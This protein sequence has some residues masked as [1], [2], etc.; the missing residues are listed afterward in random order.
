M[1]VTRCRIHKGCHEIGG[2]CVEIESTSGERILID[3]GLPLEGE[4]SM[5]D[6][7]GLFRDSTDLLGVFI[8]H[9]HPDHYGLLDQVAKTTKVFIGDAA[10]KIIAASDFFTP[11]P[12]LGDVETNPLVANETIELGPFKLTPIPIDHSAFGSFCFLIEV[13]GKRIFYSGDIRAHG[14]QGH[15][16]EDLVSNPPSNI[17]VLIC[18]GTQIGRD[19]DF[20]FPDEKSVED[21]IVTQ[22]DETKG[23]GL[24]WCSSQN[25]DRVISA[26]EAAKRTDRHLIL[27]VYSAE[28]L[29]ASGS[30]D[31]PSPNADEVHIFLPRSQKS[32]IIREKRFEITNPY[33]PNRI[34]PEKLKEVAAKSVMIFRPSMLRELEAAN[35]LSNATCITSLWA[36]YLKRD[37]KFLLKI[38]S[39]GITHKHIHTSGHATVSELKRFIAAFPA[40]RIIPIHLQDREG[41]AKMADRVE[42]K[43]DFEWW[44]V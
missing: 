32:R 15:L 21:A 17:N 38:K 37:P 5:P 25:V 35:C 10:K 8:S 31:A 40:S 41:F 36:G 1:A 23:I 33:Y 3:L 4:A 7:D 16:F 2:N 20:A 30:T 12:S 27:D 44:G 13:D 24:V 26:Y 19:P 11:L 9:A 42:L 43:N 29:K 6:V 34:Y 14:R 39:L 22:L 28:V 18:E